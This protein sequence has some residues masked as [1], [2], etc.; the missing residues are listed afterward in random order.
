MLEDPG[1]A[2]E[3]VAVAMFIGQE[4]HQGALAVEH[5]QVGY[6]VREVWLH[7]LSCVS[8]T[9]DAAEEESSVHV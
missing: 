8:D 7:L 2:V 5:D 9:S 4:Q 3:E 6:P 1:F